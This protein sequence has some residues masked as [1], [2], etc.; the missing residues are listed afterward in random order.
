MLHAVGSVHTVTAPTHND[1]VEYGKDE[2]RD[3]DDE[4][5]NHDVTSDLIKKICFHISSPSKQEGK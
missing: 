4:H 2:R 5:G 3:A 1:A